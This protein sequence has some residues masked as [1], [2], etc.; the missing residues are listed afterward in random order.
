MT[1]LHDLAQYNPSAFLL[2]IGSIIIGCCAVIHELIV[3]RR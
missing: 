3:G 2:I 1:Y